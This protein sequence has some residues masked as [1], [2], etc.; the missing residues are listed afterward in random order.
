MADNEKVILELSLDDKQYVER[1]LK[2]K[3]QLQD[4][5]DKKN[6]A[7]AGYGI[8]D[9]TKKLKD[10]GAPE[11][12][13]KFTGNMLKMA[14]PVA[15]VTGAVFALKSAFDAALEG[16][17]IKAVD[18]QFQQLASNIGL[19]AEKLRSDFMGAVDGELSMTQSL[20]LANDSMIKLGDNAKRIPEI[21]E[22]AQQRSVVMGESL[23]QSYTELSNALASG[24]E[25]ALKK[26]GLSVDAKKA[27]DDYAKSIGVA[28]S[29]L[30]DAGKK[31]AILNAAIDAGK[32][33]FQG[34]TQAVTPLSQQLDKLQAAYEDLTDYIKK[35]VAGMTIF[36][37]IAE[38]TT[39][40]VRNLGDDIKV[41]FGNEV[42][43][44]TGK[45]SQL[46]GEIKM[47]EAGIQGETPKAGF[48]DKLL[49]VDDEALARQREA[50]KQL[51]E[52]KKSEIA[53]LDKIASA[54]RGPSGEAKGGGNGVDLQAQKEQESKFN[55]ELLAMRQARVDS[56]IQLAANETQLVA[57]ENEK[58]RVL[59]EEF[60][61]Q[62]AQIKLSDT[63]PQQKMQLIEEATKTHQ[64]KLLGFERDGLSRKETM[65][66]NYQNGATSVMDGIARAAE[67][68]AQRQTIALTNSSKAGQMAF[69]SL[70][71]IGFAA[72]DALGRGA[73]TGA[74]EIGKAMLSTIGSIASNYGQMMMLASLFPFNP[75]TFAAGAALVA[76]GGFLGGAAGGGGAQASAAAPAGEDRGP[77]ATPEI[78]RREEERPMVEEAAQKKTVN[79]VV[80]G[81]IYETDQTRQRLVELIREA[82]DATDFRYDQIG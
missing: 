61:A 15:V 32:A 71:K 60:Q 56:E 19:S 42:D 81:N 52:D 17:R 5:G 62:V 50:T 2:A 49:G 46:R 55:Q 66:K 10:L 28:T 74:N 43:Q 47:L 80:Q 11:I 3:K 40:I 12:L 7:S 25:R 59:E 35:A 76:L 63:A 21:M 22:L 69:D 31:Q 37:D 41:K 8:D 16:E 24:S 34:I 51:I 57:A 44:A 36:K 53:E 13:T 39:R 27:V 70:G 67:A 45:I 48:F 73:A 64:D 82:S 75:L 79:L 23:T 18:V 77:M 33:K 9:L 58:K 14:G 6:V 65:L 4:L 29:S 1:L 38:F 72:F 78:N 30:S 26:L 68:S 54:G 20:K